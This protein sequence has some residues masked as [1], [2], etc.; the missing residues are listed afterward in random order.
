M[1]VIDG[2]DRAVIRQRKVVEHHFTVR[3][4]LDGNTLC[5]TVKNLEIIFYKPHD[6][7]SLHAL[8]HRV[9][10]PMPG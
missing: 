1:A 4:E 9:F 2:H 6:F 10:I 8:R 3:P 5:Q 7:I